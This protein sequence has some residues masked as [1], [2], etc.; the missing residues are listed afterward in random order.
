MVMH[1]YL[2]MHMC[3]KPLVKSEDWYLSLS[4][5]K[6]HLKKKKCLKL[7]IMYIHT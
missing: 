2:A 3:N 5:K 1:V 4:V 7:Y 6:K